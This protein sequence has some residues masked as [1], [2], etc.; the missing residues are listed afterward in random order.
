MYTYH[1]LA[2]VGPFFSYILS[3]FKKINEKLKTISPSHFRCVVYWKKK[4]R[5]HF[6]M[7]WPNVKSLDLLKGD[8]I[9]YQWIKSI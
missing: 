6:S 7:N 1:L 8:I 9:I 2:S 4:G 5:L 3:T